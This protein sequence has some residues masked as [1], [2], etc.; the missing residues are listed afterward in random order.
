M[1]AWAWSGRSGCAAPIVLACLLVLAVSVYGVA[2]DL[3][4]VDP[5]AKAAPAPKPA[6]GCRPKP[7]RAA[8]ADVPRGYLRLYCQAGRPLPRSPGRCWRRSARSSPTTAASG[9][10]GCVRGA[11]GP[12]RCGP[13]QIGCVP[14]EQGRQQ[15]GPLRPRPP[16]RPGQRHPGRGPLSGRP[17]RPPR[18][19][20]GPVRLQPL[21][22]L[23]RPGQAARP[24][25]QPEAV[26]DGDAGH[27]ADACPR[28]AAA[29]LDLRPPSG[30]LP[31]PLP[32]G[33]AKPTGPAPAVDVYGRPSHR[34][35]WLAGE[36]LALLE[37]QGRGV[38]VI[39][40][41]HFDRP[42]GDLANPRGFA[43]HYTGWTH[44]PAGPLAAHAAGRGARLMEVVGEAGIGWQLAR[45]WTG[46]RARNARSSGPRR[47]PR[48]PVC[49]LAPSA[50]A[51]PAGRPPALE[52]GRRAAGFTAARAAGA[53]AGG[54]RMTPT[55]PTPAEGGEPMP[56]SR[57]WLPTSQAAGRLHV[58]PKTVTRWASEGRLE[59]R[60]TLGGHRRYDPELIDALVEALTY[61][62]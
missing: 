61:R 15:L 58:T 24:P 14:G 36:Y 21:P 7:T 16:P 45:I 6:A 3:G 23:R 62:P 49:Q 42:I 33:R 4:L 57:T 25:L 8:V 47:G 56:A 38:G 60:R 29:V 52:L 31:A 34:P 53:P 13:M 2:Q 40:L 30:A 5:P 1:I 59:H 46:T 32:S 22:R 39:Y 18:P 20:P 37:A 44:R 11:T 28:A 54:G 19:R 43:G 17:R 48:C 35:P 27:R 12:G 50:S 55:R 41:L 9:C 10:P 51:S 26:G